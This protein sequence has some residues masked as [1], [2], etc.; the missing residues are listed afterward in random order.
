MDGIHFTIG[1]LQNNPPQIVAMVAMNKKEF[2]YTKVEDVAELEWDTATAPPWWDQYFLA[3]GQATITKPAAFVTLSQKEWDDFR[4][5]A[6]RSHAQ[7]Q[8]LPYEHWKGQSRPRAPYT[9]GYMSDWQQDANGNWSDMNSGQL[10]RSRQ[11]VSPY[12]GGAAS[13]RVQ[14]ET[15][16]SESNFRRP[17][18][19]K[20]D[21]LIINERIYQ[22][23]EHGQYIPA[24][25]EPITKRQQRRA[26]RKAR[27]A[28]RANPVQT[29]K[30]LDSLIDYATSK[31]LM[32]DDDWVNAS[33]DQL[34]DP[35]FW[36]ILFSEKMN[37]VANILEI[38]GLDIK[39]SMAP[40]NVIKTLKGQTTVEDYIGGSIN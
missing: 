18:W 39:Y 36:M 3:E 12:S 32:T 28:N 40:K 26:D 14:T 17:E 9:S 24:A 8:S 22:L 4:G 29:Q 35:E 21:N 31:N 2:H 10:D 16:G 5:V 20:D 30:M 23:N 7:V 13:N 19:D 25:P 37:A 34:D 11:W 1:M 38:L 6:V 15:R 27:K 33:A